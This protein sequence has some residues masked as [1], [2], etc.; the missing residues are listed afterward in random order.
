MQNQIVSF[1]G[2]FL[3]LCLVTAGSDAYSHDFSGPHGTVSLDWDV[4]HVNRV[5][6]SGYGDSFGTEAWSRRGFPETLDIDGR[7]CL[8]GTYFLFDVDDT[9]AFDIDETV[10]IEVLFER[11]RSRGFIFAYDQ[12][13]ISENAQDYVFA[14]SNRKWHTQ[15]VTLDRA[16]FANRGES[17][18]DFAITAL[19]GTWFGDPNADHRIVICDLKITRSNETITPTRFG[20][21]HLTIRT[22]NG[23]LTPARVGLYNGSRRMPLPSDSALTINNYDDRTRQ[24]FLRETHDTVPPWPHQNRYFFYVDGKYEAR[25]PVG[26]YT[27]VVS[28][29]PEYDR[30]E[31]VLTIRDGEVTTVDLA[32]SRWINMP[33]R[34]WYSGDGHVHM[35][36]TPDDNAAISAIMKAEDVHV[37]N[38]L[39]LG[40]PFDT[41]FKQYAFGENGRFEDGDNALVPGVEDPRTA[42]RGHTISMNI[43]EVARQMENYL[44]YDRTFA[45]YREQGGISGYAHVAGRLFNVERGLA[46][47]VPLG[48]VDFA[49]VLQDGIL[50]TDLWYDFL[51]LGF[52]LTPTAGSDFP[53]LNVPG[54]DR[55]YVYVGDNFDVD[56][57]FAG[58]GGG[59]AFVTNG[60][61]LDLSVNGAPMGSDIQVSKGD[62][63]EIVASATLNPDTEPINRLELIVHGDVAARSVKTDDSNSLFLHHTVHASEGIWLAVRAYGEYQA[64]AHSSP[65]YITIDG[66]FEKREDVAEIVADMIARLDAFKTVEAD[67]AQELEAWSVGE[68]LKSMLHIQRTRILE[69]ADAARAIYMHLSERH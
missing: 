17:R 41:H 25:L 60:P 28:K 35:T 33:A 63:I 34:G 55:G 3:A 32:L 47:D 57:W 5:L 58:L 46:I 40:N 4:A 43:R 10:T 64:V 13:G 15:T 37:A 61:M 59:H 23:Q 66:G 22:E 24:I 68:L 44:L 31:R 26:E 2:R 19:D 56:T 50:E 27:L 53:Y 42:I 9:F 45:E 7:R 29:G 69:R 6:S 30:D 36:R 21:L 38:L 18:T 48:D 52:K 16:R 12:N 54:G 14:Q 62:K 67:S 8:H 49:E 39:Q 20:E 51:N 65:V 1:L 11:S